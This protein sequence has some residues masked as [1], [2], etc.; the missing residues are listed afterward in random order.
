MFKGDQGCFEDSKTNVD[1]VG[2]K[3]D[4]KRTRRMFT[5]Q[6]SVH[7]GVSQI[8]RKGKFFPVF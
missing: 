4:L 1:E 6:S 7:G 8:S 3:V 5:F 2:R